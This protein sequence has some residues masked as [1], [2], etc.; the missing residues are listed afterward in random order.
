MQIED[1]AVHLSSNNQ[2]RPF[3]PALLPATSLV[4]TENLPTVQ[5]LESHHAERARLERY[6]HDRFARE[7]GANIN[8]YMPFLIRYGS[9]IQT[10]AAVGFRTASDHCLFLETYLDKA[11]EHELMDITGLDISRKKIIEVGNLAATQH[12]AS[13]PLFGALACF[14]DCAGY[15]WVVICATPTVQN[16]FSK[17]QIPLIRL[18]EANKEALSGDQQTLWGNYYDC[19]PQVMAV[20]VRTAHR[21]VRDSAIG[22]RL[23]A[24]L[25]PSINRMVAKWDDPYAH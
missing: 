9:N 16:V 1:F 11:I 25:Y 4:T 13:A 10:Y 23:L 17:L 15:E 21:C 18:T 5:L 8:K 20:H 19:K 12:G 6:I 2:T 24:T 7:Y 14:L 3:P 22:K